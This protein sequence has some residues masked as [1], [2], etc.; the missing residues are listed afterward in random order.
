MKTALIPFFF[1]ASVLAALPLLPDPEPIL[2]PAGTERHP[3]RFEVRQTKRENRVMPFPSFQS[4]EKSVRT[5]VDTLNRPVRKVNPYFAIF[6]KK[7]AAVTF[8]WGGAFAGM[9]WG[10]PYEDIPGDPCRIT[11]DEKNNSTTYIKPY[12]NREG[13]R[14]EFICTMRALPDGKLE[15]A[16]NV[17]A[18]FYVTLHNYRG[19]P[20]RIGGKKLKQADGETLRNTPVRT[21]VSGII[22]YDSQDPAR[23]I[24]VDIP[25]LNANI[26]EKRHIYPKYGVDNCTLEL[27]ISPK[28]RRVTIDLGESAAL[29]SSVSVQPPVFGVDLWKADATHV[30]LFPT[31]NIF[32]NPGFEQGCRFWRWNAHGVHKFNPDSPLLKYDTVEQPHTGRRA[33]VIR[34][35]RNGSR[36]I[37]SFP[38]LLENGKKY[39][40]SFYAKALG[41]NKRFT[42]SIRNAGQGGKITRWIYGDT[43]NKESQFMLTNE[44]KRYS[45]TFTADRAGIQVMFSGSD[46]LVDSVQLEAGEKATPFVCAPLESV[47]TT[48]G[49]WN[50]SHADVPLE[51]KLEIFGKPGTEGKVTV[52]IAN[53]FREELYKKTF[54]V[55]IGASGCAELIPDLGDPGTGVFTIRTGFQ[56]AGFPEWTQID[57]FSRIRPLKGKHASKNM[58]GS[59]IQERA[60]RSDIIFRRYMEWGIGS[61]SWFHVFPDHKYD[62]NRIPPEKERILN[63]FRKYG[64]S[65]LISVPGKHWKHLEYKPDPR[66]MR[67]VTPEIE[68]KIEEAACEF[69]RKMPQDQ[70]PCVAFANED[71]S[72]YLPGSGQYDEY[73]KAQLAT[74]RG[75]KRANP[76]VKVAPTHGTSGWSRI[77]GYDPVDNYLKAAKKAGIL[78]DV[79][80]VHPYGNYG[81]VFDQGA[82]HLLDT[83]KKYGYPESTNILFSEHGN[84]SETFVP[85]WEP[86]G[87]LDI[88]SAGKLSYDFGLREL[89]QATNYVGCAIIGMKYHPRLLGINFWTLNPYL[90]IRLIPTIFP[91]CVN[92][93]GNILPDARFHSEIM[94]AANILC[95]IFRR[96]DGKAVAV[97]W[98][99][100]P[101][102]AALRKRNPKLHTKFNRTVRFFDF[103]GNERRAKTAN[104][105]TEIPVTPC[106]LY[107][108]ADNVDGL[109]QELRRATVDNA[110]APWK[111]AVYPEKSGAVVMTVEN[112]T[113]TERQGTLLLDGKRFPFRTPGKGSAA[114]RL[115]NPGAEYGK[116]YSWDRDYSLIGQ[117]VKIQSEWNMNYFFVP[118]TEGMPDWEKIP[119]IPITNRFAQPHKKPDQI[120]SDMTA[121]FRLAWSRENLWLRVEVRD[122]QYLLF[123]ELWQTVGNIRSHL[124]RF[125]GALE[126]YFDTAADARKKKTNNYDE[127]DYRYD[128]CAGP[129]GKSGR[130]CVYRLR[131]VYH[132][133][134]DGVNMPTKKEAS[135]KVIC[136]FE[137]LPGGYAYTIKFGQRYLEPFTLRSGSCAGF[138]I[139]LH[140][141]DK[142]PDGSIR[143]GGLSNST[144]DGTPC[145]YKP[146]FWPLM[147][148]K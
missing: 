5:L 8:S 34:N 129:S 2:A 74:Y 135:E 132:Q 143:Y 45:R 87:N 104:G 78:Y 126:V 138:G 82:Q 115:G 58:T 59:L 103:T 108:V 84:A 49:E 75:A 105:I 31:R 123:P 92:A 79:V 11:C 127:N 40:L 12:K 136:N 137:L 117:D 140:D 65:N 86:M 3:L 1:S 22:R 125:D 52:S 88:Y 130:G 16:W 141:R 120:A 110:E 26:T 73:A 128:F 6:V 15:L 133:L 25:D 148:L 55:R 68:K 69:V 142:N 85:G 106:P 56:V 43:K 107:L 109:A 24:V 51:P 114:I 29:K 21:K 42:A 61:T 139:F 47:F 124:Y 37:L 14:A 121:V 89:K 33:L 66:E 38:M 35:V 93:F 27:M 4:G 53:L 30:P 146:K 134:A 145:D 131:E 7:D 23:D 101:E 48:S 62:E 119:A 46:V 91:A 95:Y 60:D 18:L 54:S 28:E 9:K 116:L 111:T 57:R 77:R 97:L 17:N 83:M 100:D 39:T 94:P 96:N 99:D 13:K 113:G 90:D 44:W 102:T 70:L 32:P 20:V 67:K 147:I 76:N 98:N 112:Q 72:S 36:N 118:R 63:L 80:S 64:I 41:D 50:Q 81:R 144:E 10:S 71:E 122:A 19:K